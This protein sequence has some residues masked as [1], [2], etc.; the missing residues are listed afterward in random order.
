MPTQSR[1]K[2]TLADRH[3]S[4]QSAEE[5]DAIRRLIDELI[6]ARGTTMKAASLAIGRNPTYIQQFIKTGTPEKLKE[7]DREKLE[8]FLGVPRDTLK[9]PSGS[10]RVATRGVAVQKS[11]AKFAHTLPATTK[12][13]LPLRGRAVGGGRDVLIFGN[14]DIRGYIERPPHLEGDLDAF[15]VAAVGDSMEPRYF[16]G[17]ILH[18]STLKPAIVGDFV[19]I[20]L[21]DDTAL[22]K[23]LIRQT[24]TEVVLEQYNPP[25]TFA[26]PLAQIRHIY[27]IVGTAGR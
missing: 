2:S 17:E 11:E 16:H 7:E 6:K 20:E 12:R 21:I 25:K 18:V 10:I 5:M 14:G 15:A 9:N 23:R 19:L 4:F 13:D 22:I 24:A 8:D 26:V 27:R 1:G 3:H